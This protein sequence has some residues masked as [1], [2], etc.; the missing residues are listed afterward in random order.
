MWIT[1]VSYLISMVVTQS[2]D[3]LFKL[4]NY[5]THTS[6]LAMKLNKAMDTN[7]RV[8]AKY[9]TRTTAMTRTLSADVLVSGAAHNAVLRTNKEPLPNKFK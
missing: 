7:K 2:I 9:C 5:C 1:Q 8:G 3:Y 6:E 4:H